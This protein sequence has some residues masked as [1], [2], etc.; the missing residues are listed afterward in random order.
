MALLTVKRT[1]TPGYCRRHSRLAGLVL[2]LAALGTSVAVPADAASEPVKVVARADK[3]IVSIGDTLSLNL[4][5][6]WESGVDVK[7]VA[8]RERLGNFVVRDVREGETRPSDNGFARRT[9]LLLTVFETGEQTI[10]GLPVLFTAPDGKPGR[11]ET[12]PVSVTVES[13]LSEEEQEIRDIK[14]PLSVKKRWK[15]IILS[16]ALLIGLAGAAATSVLVSVRK[17]SDIEALARRLW[18]RI[19]RPLGVL[20]AWLLRLLALRKK[21]G[22]V[23]YRIEEAGPEI[24]PEEAAFRELARIEELGLIEKGLIKDLYTLVSE[25]LRRY[26]ERKSG[27]LAMELPTSY[28]MSEMAG[29]GIMSECHAELREV[30]EEGDLVK[31]AKYI[32]QDEAARSVISRARDIVR[33]TSAARNRTAGTPGEGPGMPGI[34]LEA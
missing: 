3:R 5:I 17:K 24:P 25:V 12:D 13:V 27:V 28:I 2:I 4:D 20:A 26:I 22:P 11:V 10:P 30:L 8:A 15:E 7:P 1:V 34:D 14:P 23:A 18:E 6:E 21:T 29:R 19:T 16:Y 33:R 31:F 32:P 9:S